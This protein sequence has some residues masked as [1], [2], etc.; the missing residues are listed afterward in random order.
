V[1]SSWWVLP[2]FLEGVE[3]ALLF[4]L[5]VFL[6]YF[7]GKKKPPTLSSRGSFKSITGNLDF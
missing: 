7:Q 3:V 1:G 2:G 6:S 4:F 5:N